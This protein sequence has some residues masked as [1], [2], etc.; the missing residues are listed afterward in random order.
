MR[1]LIIIIMLLPL[2]GLA[3]TKVNLPSGTQYLGSAGTNVIVTSGTAITKV[4]VLDTSNT[5]AVGRVTVKSPIVVAVGGKTY[6]ISADTSTSSTGL[7]T[8][9]KNG[10]KLSISDTASMLANYYK[11]ATATSALA[12]K[13]DSVK[14]KAAT[15]SVFYYTGG[16][17]HFAFRDSAGS[18]GGGVSTASVPL[19]VTGSN[20]TLTKTGIDTVGTIVSG[21]WN[22]AN[23]DYNLLAMQALGSTLKAVVFGISLAQLSAN[24]NLTSG[25]AYYYAVYVPKTI[26][27]TGVKWYQGTAANAI[28][29]TSSYNGFG[30][31]SY[32]GG[33]LTMIDSTERDTAIFYKSQQV[34]SKV[35]PSTHTLSVGIYFIS[36]HY[37]YIAQISAPSFGASAVAT[38]LAVYGGDFTNSAAIAA[39]NFSASTP[40][41]SEPMSGLAKITQIIFLGLY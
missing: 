4:A 16:T 40:Q 35:F 8:L 27:V 10:L 41:A 28:E 5:M 23:V 11:T 26:L 30:L 12:L 37:N 7:T 31:Y 1:R 22:G 17:S 36:V 2:F 39:Q 18:G 29:T 21:T 34:R 19:V 6:Q 25:R 14:K 24:V 32:S 13:T 9:Y 15:D 38:N 20:M 3:Q 33:T